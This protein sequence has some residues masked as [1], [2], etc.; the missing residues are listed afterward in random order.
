M[1][2]HRKKNRP[3]LQRHDIWTVSLGSSFC[4]HLIGHL[5]K[6][7]PTQFLVVLFFIALYTS[8]FSSEHFF[9]GLFFF[10]FFFFL[11]LCLPSYSA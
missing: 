4:F 11:G 8:P 5:L 10:F 2:I 3:A 1:V 6:S 7:S 9:L